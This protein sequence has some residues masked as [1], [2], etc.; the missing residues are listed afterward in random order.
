[1]SEKLKASEQRVKVLF[2]NIQNTCLENGT[3]M[4]VQEMLLALS[5]YTNSL[6]LFGIKDSIEKSDI[7]DSK[8]LDK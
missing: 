1:M 3:G 8:Q 4:S 7:E 6:L 2:D 5:S